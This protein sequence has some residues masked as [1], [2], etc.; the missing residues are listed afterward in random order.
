MDSHSARAGV[1]RAATSKK[2]IANIF[3]MRHLLF[4]W[5]KYTHDLIKYQIYFC[6]YSNYAAS[7]P[8]PTDFIAVKAYGL[9]SGGKL[10]GQTLAQHLFDLGV[11]VRRGQVLE[12]GAVAGD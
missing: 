7:A 12:I 8:Q 9:F 4:L 5:P 10:A 11:K 3:L 1:T 2:C 6:F